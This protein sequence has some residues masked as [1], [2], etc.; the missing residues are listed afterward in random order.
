MGPTKAV[1]KD[2]GIYDAKTGKLIKDGFP[3]PEA[4]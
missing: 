4:I 3:T 1:V 2:C